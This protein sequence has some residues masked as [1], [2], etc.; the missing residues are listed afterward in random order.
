LLPALPL[1]Y[2]RNTLFLSGT[3]NDNLFT[4]KKYRLQNTSN[5]ILSEVAPNNEM[6]VSYDVM[7]GEGYNIPSSLCANKNFA[8]VSDI[9]SDKNGENSGSLI[10]FDRYMKDEFD[11]TQELYIS[12]PGSNG[13]YNIKILNGY[14]F[15]SAINESIDNVEGVG[16]IYIFEIV[17]L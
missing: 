8:I 1:N 16:K 2:T 5:V 14:L 3:T 7:L 4:S 6:W 13:G 10:I 15:Y 11:K 9:Y 17:T 12:P